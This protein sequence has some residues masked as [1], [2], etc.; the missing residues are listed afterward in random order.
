MGARMLK[1]W[2]LGPLLDQE[3]IDDRLDAI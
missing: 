3:Q 2:L 1:N